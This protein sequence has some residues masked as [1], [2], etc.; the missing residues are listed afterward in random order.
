MFNLSSF[1]CVIVYLQV[2]VFIFILLGMGTM[3]A[4]VFKCCASVRR[5]YRYVQFNQLC[6]NEQPKKSLLNKSGVDGLGFLIFQFH[7]S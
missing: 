6:Q 7:T 4:F 3:H 1:L 5:P 2:I